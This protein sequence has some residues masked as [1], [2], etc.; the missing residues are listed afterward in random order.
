[1]AKK[2]TED[3]EILNSMATNLLDALAVFPKQLIHLDQLVREFE[4]PL[5]HIQIL[6]VL[7]GGDLSIGSLSEKMGIAKPNITPLVDT[8]CRKQLVERIRS[9]VDRRVVNV[10]LTA[11]GVKLLDRV[12]ESVSRQVTEWSIPL[13]RSEAKELNAALA[14]LLRLCKDNRADDKAAEQAAE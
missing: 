11:E 6:V 7:A 8:L 13:S 3:A 14:S 5:S 2:W 4:M 9:E 1:M 10:H 12:R